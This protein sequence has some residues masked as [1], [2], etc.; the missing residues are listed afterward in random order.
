M[1]TDRI[2]SGSH[3]QNY[4]QN[5]ASGRNELS[6]TCITTWVQ[7]CYCANKRYCTRLMLDWTWGR[8]CRGCIW[9]RC[10]TG[11]RRGC[12]SRCPTS[13][14]RRRWCC[15][16]GTQS[17][18]RYQVRFSWK[19]YCKQDPGE[20]YF[21]NTV[22]WDYHCKKNSLSLFQLLAGMSLTKLFLAGNLLHLWRLEFSR[23][24][25][26]RVRNLKGPN[27]LSQRPN[28]MATLAAAPVA[29]QEYSGNFP[30]SRL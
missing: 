9:W 30:W 11:G 18:S 13:P 28:F 17:D 4:M 25:L 19:Q 26:F 23:I 1:S 29:S 24:F 21:G 22:R 20:I 15:T 16:C 6:S 3:F 10:L 8:G 5:K 2:E 12:P 14:R 27:F 7:Y